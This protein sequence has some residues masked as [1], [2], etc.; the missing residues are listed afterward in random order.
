MGGDI[1]GGT[2]LQYRT[3]MQNTAPGLGF[4]GEEDNTEGG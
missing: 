1:A 2:S 3:E 4:R